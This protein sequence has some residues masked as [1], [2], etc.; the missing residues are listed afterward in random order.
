M[1]QT[2]ILR[3]E[4]VEQSPPVLNIGG[5]SSLVDHMLS[6]VEEVDLDGD[7]YYVAKPYVIVAN[8]DEVEVTVQDDTKALAKIDT[9][10]SVLAD[11]E[12][13]TQV[14][15]YASAQAGTYRILNKDVNWSNQ[16]TRRHNLP[17]PRPYHNFLKQKILG[18]L[19][20]LFS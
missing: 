5:F 15:T 20:S 17:N 18:L 3:L 13:A 2:I 12:V 1:I 7:I 11:T 8:D 9:D 4:L 19:I 10:V 14:D 16:L 6:S